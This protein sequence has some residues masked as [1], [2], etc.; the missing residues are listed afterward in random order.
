METSSV[1]ERNAARVFLSYSWADKALAR[2][3]AR[4]LAQSGI[5]VFL[6]EE[7]L[8]GGQ[9]LTDSLKREIL[10]STHVV[11]SW[12]NSAVESAWV[13]KELEFAAAAA[14]RPIV[15]PLLFVPPGKNPIVQDSVGIEFFRR[16]R[17]EESLAKLLQIVS[18]G[19]LKE[20]ELQTLHDDLAKTV[21]ECPALEPIIRNPLAGNFFPRKSAVEIAVSPEAR[22]QEL[23]AASK[24]FKEWQAGRITAAGLPGPDDDDFHALDFGLWC[25]AQITMF[26]R[27]ELAP[28]HPPEIMTYP[29]IFGGVV[30]AT[31][32]GFEAALML[33]KYYP[34]LAAS[35]FN[36]IAV[37]DAVISDEGLPVVVEL[38]E[39]V[40]NLV[41]KDSTLDSLAR[42]QFLPLSSAELFLRYQFDR[43]SERQK[44]VILRLSE[45]NGNSPYPGPPLQILAHLRREP[46]LAGEM[47]RRMRLWA[48]SGLFDGYDTQ[49]R[50]ESPGM[51]YTFTL[52]AENDERAGLLQ[53][54]RERIRKLFRSSDSQDVTPALRWIRDAARLP[55]PHRGVIEEAFME[56]VYSSEFESQPYAQVVGPTA[57]VL[58]RA[59]LDEDDETLRRSQGIV[60]ATL[61][62]AGLLS[63]IK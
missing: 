3:I 42:D 53:V 10:A 59:L 37:R 2:R 50:S 20:P 18:G 17:F 57:Q 1:V 40:F 11:V 55:R 14:P 32:A 7:Q 4:R 58:V 49:R 60:D 33:L 43:L 34:G 56:G 39:A 21:E 5:D 22:K 23:D 35:T 38:F 44:R 47:A 6:D 15:I 30:A 52:V 16:H 28:L 19:T 24:R 12:T 29:A 9:P 26:R 46:A 48:E 41:M 62:K 13:Q 45:S 31:T 63:G 61:K 25:A 51:Y 36:Q 27:A 54:A 8:G